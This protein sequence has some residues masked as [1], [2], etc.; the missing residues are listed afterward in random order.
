MPLTR[1]PAPTSA[2][3]DG[4]DLSAARQAFCAALKAARE[5]RGLKLTDI[6]ATTKVCPSYFSALERNDLRVWP[7]GLFRRSFFRGYVTTIGL[8]VNE[9]LAEFTRLFPENEGAASE[10]P[11][12]ASAAAAAPKP[13]PTQ[14]FRLA[15]DESFGG[16]KVPF[17]IRIA[18]AV[19]DVVVVA[20]M[21]VVATW[22]AS[23]QFA[24]AFASIALTYFTLATALFAESP[25]LF[26]LRRR[27]H[28]VEALESIFAPA[29]D[30]APRQG[31]IRD[32]RPWTT[33]ARRVR[34]RDQGTGLR[35]RFKVSS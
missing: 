11:A 4:E 14:E 34:P 24:P 31:E 6:S 17:A 21:A 10:I 13:A 27:G 30:E 32:E 33:D 7:K 26:C 2:M 5:K 35:V 22:A 20:L 12:S 1:D 8:P 25:A 23:L 29:R 15:L 16:S 19:I 3:P 9:L 18:A 28:I